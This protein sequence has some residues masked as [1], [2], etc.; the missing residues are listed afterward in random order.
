M[1]R[2]L[3]SVPRGARPP[4]PGKGRLSSSPRPGSAPRM[5]GAHGA[6]RPAGQ[7]RAARFLVGRFRGEGRFVTTGDVFEKEVVGAY[8]AGGRFISLRMQ[9]SYPLP[10]GGSDVHRALVVVGADARSG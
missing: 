1:R 10:D 8:E 6:W 4:P 7:L 9:A 3:R 5:D 2:G